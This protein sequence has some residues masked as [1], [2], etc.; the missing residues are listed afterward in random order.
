M[1]LPWRSDSADTRVYGRDWFAARA[2]ATRSSAEAIMPYIIET[3]RPQSIVD[4]GCG[5]GSWLAAATERGVARV[6]GIDGDWVDRDGLEIPIECF[7][8]RDLVHDRISLGERFDLA[9]SLEVAE[10]LPAERASTF[11]HELVTLAPVVLF[12]AA[13]PFQGGTGHQNEQWPEYWA[14]IFAAHDYIGVDCVRPRYWN[15]E[16]VRY[17]YAQNAVLYVARTKLNELPGLDEFSGTGE[18]IRPLVHPHLY[19]NALRRFPRPEDADVQGF[20][21]FLARWGKSLARRGR[22]A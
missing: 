13:V 18:S 20:G 21:R 4:V 8:P 6:V 15:D 10:H 16:R 17:F 5:P 1:A 11:V 22:R 2:S 19:L 9:V 14:Q 3:V 12:S 7:V